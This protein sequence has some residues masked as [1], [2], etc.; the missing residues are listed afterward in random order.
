VA[1]PRIA[2]NPYRTGIQGVFICSAATPPG[3]GVHGSNGYNAAQTVLRDA[4][5]G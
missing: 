3:G 2:L 1:R 5:N 4:A